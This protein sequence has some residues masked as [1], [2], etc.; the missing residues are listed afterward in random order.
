MLLVLVKAADRMKIC[1]ITEQAFDTH[2]HIVTNLFKL[3]SGV[4]YEYIEQEQDGKS[5]NCYEY[6]SIESPNGTFCSENPG[7][8]FSKIRG[9]NYHRK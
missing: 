3:Y 1:Q 5:K 2:G 6:V 9:K 4:V 7:V 8:P